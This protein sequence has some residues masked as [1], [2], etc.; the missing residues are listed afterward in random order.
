[1]QAGQGAVNFKQEFF[2]AHSTMGTHDLNPTVV[3]VSLLLHGKSTK[4]GAQVNLQLSTNTTAEMLL[5]P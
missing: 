3:N 2:A 5:Q 1:M 4:N